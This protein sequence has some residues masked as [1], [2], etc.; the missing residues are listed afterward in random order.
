M[1]EGQSRF[2]SINQYPPNVSA[3]SV[4]VRLIDGL[5]FRFRWATE[6]LGDADV[7]FRPGAESYTIGEITGH[8]WGLVNWVNLSVSGTGS[9]RPTEYSRLRDKVLDMLWMLRDN[10]LALD[11][12]DLE[13]CTID[14]LP[15]W[16]IINGPL[17]DALTHVGQIN[18]FR[19][20]SGN[21]TPKAN[22]FRGLPPGAA[23]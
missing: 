7:A 15:F 21:P 3:A 9:E 19:R 13:R 8:I 2:D 6:G 16:H 10:V 22:V 20:L 12:A 18:V 14:G 4:L 1:T 5:G 11:D 17:S 23:A